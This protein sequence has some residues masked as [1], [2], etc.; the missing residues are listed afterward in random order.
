MVIMGFILTFTTVIFYDI[1]LPAAEQAY[2]FSN[3]KGFVK[4][5]VWL[6]VAFA[7]TFN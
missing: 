6:L 2:L 3:K 7:L 4:D 5:K 1:V